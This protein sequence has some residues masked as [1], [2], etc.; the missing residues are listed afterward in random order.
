MARVMEETVLQ[1]SSVFWPLNGMPE[2]LRD[3]C[4]LRWKLK[5]ERDGIAPGLWETLC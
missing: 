5:E 1:Y 3:R 4:A 2:V